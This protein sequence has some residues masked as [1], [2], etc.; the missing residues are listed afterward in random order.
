MRLIVN[1]D[2]EYTDISM[3]KA[4]TTNPKAY[5]NVCVCVWGG[6]GVMSQ[7]RYIKI[8]KYINS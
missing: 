3:N 4:K 6:G 1:V 7:E 5:F 2:T 8:V